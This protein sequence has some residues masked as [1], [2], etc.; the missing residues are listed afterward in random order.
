LLKQEFELED[1]AANFG[2]V[3]MNKKTFDSL[4]EMTEPAST[5]DSCY[6]QSIS[7]GERQYLMLR[8]NW[9]M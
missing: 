3:R 7:A 1:P 6:I 5:G 9:L 2:Y 4:L 8:K